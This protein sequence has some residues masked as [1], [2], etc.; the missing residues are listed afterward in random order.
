MLPVRLAGLSI[1][2]LAEQPVILFVPA[3]E[4]EEL[5]TRALPIWIGHAEATSILMA[6]QGIETPRPM[7]HD[8]LRDVIDA[9]GYSVDRVEITRL[10]NGTF[11]ANLVLVSGDF[12]ISVDARPSDSIALSVRV[13]CPIYV[14]EEVFESAA[15][16]ITATVDEEEEIQR[17]RDFLDTVD[18]SDFQS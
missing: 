10:E 5:P 13:G 3:E 16:E 6:L 2:S 18:P 11:Y 17:F 8:L 7:T 14:D 9:L 4:K 1:D 15:V 12:E